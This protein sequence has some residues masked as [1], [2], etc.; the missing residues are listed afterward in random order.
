MQLI[1]Y[2]PVN[3]NQAFVIRFSRDFL[4]NDVC[5]YFKD[6]SLN[7]RH[8]MIFMEGGAPNQYS[9]QVKNYLE[10]KCS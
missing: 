2:H 4:Q 1:V 3:H 9:L 8:D 10:R 6:M 7:I 5:D